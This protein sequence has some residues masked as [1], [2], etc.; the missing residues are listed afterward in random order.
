MLGAILERA[1]GKPYASL[2]QEF[3]LGPLGLHDT[4]LQF[5]DNP[6]L[7]VVHTLDDG[8]FKD[9]TFWNPSFVSWAS[10]TSTVCDLGTWNR[11]FG[12]SALLSA[13]LKSQVTAPVNVGLGQNTASSY[14]GLG[15]LVKKP[16]ILATAS[17]WGM[18]TS[19]AYDPTTGISLA[20]TVSL[21]PGAAP[22]NPS[23]DILSAISKVL[24]P[25]HPIQY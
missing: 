15:T 13:A 20:V 5:D 24:T 3:I 9:T 12:T 18:Y 6:Q 16:W 23:D 25:G 17:Y 4:R 11:A 22:K 7:P 21:N 10:M 1:G 8:T 2:L 14:F 19:T